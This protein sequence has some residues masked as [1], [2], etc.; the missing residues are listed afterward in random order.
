MA[1]LAAAMAC[2]GDACADRACAER[3]R[4]GPFT[5]PATAPKKAEGASDGD[6]IDIDADVGRKT[7][8]VRMSTSWECVKDE[9][10]NADFS[11]SPQANELLRAKDTNSLKALAEAM[12]A[13]VRKRTF[14]PQKGYAVNHFDYCYVTLPSVVAAVFSLVRDF[15]VAPTQKRRLLAFALRDFDEYPTEWYVLTCRS[16]TTHNTVCQLAPNTQASRERLQTF[17]DE[18]PSM[19]DGRITFSMSAFRNRKGTAEKLNASLEYTRGEMMSA[20]RLEVEGEIRDFVETAFGEEDSSKYEFDVDHLHH[21]RF[22]DLLNCFLEGECLELCNVKLS[23][24]IRSLYIADRRLAEKWRS[25]HFGNSALQVIL[26]DVH[27]R[28]TAADNR[29]KYQKDGTIHIVVTRCKGDLM[30]DVERRYFFPVKLG[31]TEVTMD[32]DQKVCPQLLEHHD[33]GDRNAHKVRATLKLA[34]VTDGAQSINLDPFP[35]GYYNGICSFAFLIE[36]RHYILKFKQYSIKLVED[37]G[38]EDQ[39]ETVDAGERAALG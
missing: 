1:D 39:A 9:N 7:T 31:K 30:N 32:M 33:F 29:L 27:L 18:N 5:L 8:I 19:L 15:Y 2:A 11:S 22:V 35:V 13:E 6:A 23:G 36:K 10:G 20:F 34:G 14:D 25:F 28:N 26:R 12:C 4:H 3:A 16:L 37:D 24:G 17:R 21:T 38:D